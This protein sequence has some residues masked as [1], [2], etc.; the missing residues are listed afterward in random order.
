MEIQKTEDKIPKKMQNVF[1][2]LA[3][4][5]YPLKNVVKCF[6]DYEVWLKDPIWQPTFVRSNC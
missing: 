5:N 6:D 3:L 4:L 1:R 2:I